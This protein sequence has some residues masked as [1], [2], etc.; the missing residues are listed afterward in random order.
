ME[1]TGP[2]PRQ[3]AFVLDSLCDGYLVFCDLPASV[4]P[5][6]GDCTLN[7]WE[8]LYHLHSV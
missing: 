1:G 4:L 2:T 3:I 7:L 5:S 6:F 8:R